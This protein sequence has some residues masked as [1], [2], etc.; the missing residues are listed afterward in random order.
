MRELFSFKISIYVIFICGIALGSVNIINEYQ[1]YACRIL[2]V[3]A[4]SYYIFAEIYLRL[5][6]KP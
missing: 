2:G 5:K 6:S 4:V 3:I 1:L